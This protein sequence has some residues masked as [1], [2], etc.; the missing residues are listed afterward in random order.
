VASI[1]YAV[2]ATDAASA[3]FA[4]IAASADGLD[5]QLEDLGKRVA[6]PEVQLDD[7][8]ATLG[9]IRA[10]ERLD[11]LSAKVADPSVHLDDAKAQT[12]ILRINAMLDRLG[13]KKVTATV[14]VDVD[15]HGLMSRLGGFGGGGGILGLLGSAAGSAGGAVASAAGPAAIGLTSLIGGVTALAAALAAVAFA[16][17]A[18]GGAIT[19]GLGGA[20][21]GIAVLGAMKSKAVKSAFADLAK[22]ANHDLAQIGKPFIPVL[23]SIARTAKSV[24]GGLTPVFRSAAGVISGPFKTF[25]DTLIKAFGQPAVKQAIQ[26]SAAAFAAILKAVTP[27]LAGNIKTLANGVTNIAK[28]V[29]ANPQAFADF[30]NFLFK[31]AGFALNAIAWLTRVATY[32]ER[33]F[34]PAVHEIAV[35]FDGVRHDIAHIWD[36]I[37]ENSIGTVIRFGHDVERDF[38]DFRHRTAV[39]FDGIRHDIAHIWDMIWNNTIGRMIRGQQDMFKLGDEWRH[40]IANTWDGLRHDIA[41]IW[42]VAWNNTVGRAIRG[43]QDVQRVLRAGFRGAI[44]WLYQAGKDVIQGLWNGLTFIWHKVTGFISGIAG[45]IKAHKGPVGL[46]ARLLEPAGR[47]LMSGLRIGLLGEWHTIASWISGIGGQISAILHGG[48]PAGSKA[49]TGA[50]GLGRAMAAARGWT[51][52][53]WDALFALWQRESGWNRLARNPSSGAAGIPQDITGNFHG[54]ALGQILWGL[55]YIAG[56]YGSPVAAWQHEMRY[57]WYDRGGWLP[58]GLSLAMNTTGRPERVGGGNVTYNLT[59]NAPVGS[60]PRDVGRQIVGYIKSFEAGSGASWRR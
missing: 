27:G 5:S 11:K 55:N 57:G 9:M 1:E 37:F 16:A 18:A 58:P 17:Q 52:T 47:A 48:I 32:I 49:I 21:A 7:A 4:K 29:A 30:I 2:R 3:V 26:A 53:Q 51:G 12:E 42:D 34:K 56:R 39:V 20:I 35:I 38:N 24:L 41:H 13:A 54:G 59:V 36:Q 40:H 22:S 33:H 28:A 15:R 45:W 44:H 46:D 43:I 8:K 14:A 25:A 19:L 50:V 23:E 31:I 6:A 10:A 60:N